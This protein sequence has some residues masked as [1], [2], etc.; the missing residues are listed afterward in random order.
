MSAAIR[1]GEAIAGRLFGPFDQAAILAYADAS[2]D[3]N[4]LHVDPS[5]AARAGLADVPIHGMLMMGCFE[6]FL[7]D[8]KPGVVVRKLSAKFIRPILVGEAFE[9]SGKVVQAPPDAPA[10]V[11]LMVKREGSARDLVLM[12]EA[13]VTP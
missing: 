8:W 10:V 11:R 4:P 13:F 9:I 3:D 5:I 12:A 6:T 7:R 2:G 1:Q